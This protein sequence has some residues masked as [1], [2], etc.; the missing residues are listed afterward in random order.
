MKQTL[1]VAVAGLIGLQIVPVTGS[2][3]EWGLGLGIAGQQPPQEGADRQVVALPFPS[4]EGERLSAS[5]GS[6]AYALSATDRYRFAIEGQLRFDGYDPD[7]SAA[8]AGLE[9]RDATLD[10]GVSLTTRQDWGIASLKLMADALSVHEGYEVSASYQYPLQFERWTVVPVI[11]AA[12]SSDNL[13]EY[14]YGVRTNEARLDRPAYA[15]GATVNTSM[16]INVSYE[17]AQN[18]E[19]IGGVEYT[20]L[21]DEITDSPIIEKDSETIV[22]SAIVYH[23]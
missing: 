14:Y 15:G 12:W 4:Y 21:G 6:I 7:D 10:A 2:A 11:T 16:A 5:F 13:V 8:L 20:L 18:W 19:V 17:V 9:E 3:G 22:Y 23:F 1:V